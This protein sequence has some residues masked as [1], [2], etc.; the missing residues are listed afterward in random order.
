MGEETNIAD[1]LQNEGWFLQN[2]I[3]CDVIECVVM[4]GM[5]SRRRVVVSV[6]RVQGRKKQIHQTPT[7]CNIL[8]NIMVCIQLHKT[9]TFLS[10]ALK[11]QSWVENFD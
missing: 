4:V 2:Y 3:F 7:D 11:L 1:A 8:Q 9:K 6:K 10:M 5:Q